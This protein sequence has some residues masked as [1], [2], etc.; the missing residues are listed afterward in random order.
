MLELG[1][2]EGQLMAESKSFSE[3]IAPNNSEE[4]RAKADASWSKLGTNSF[5][6]INYVRLLFYS[7]FRLSFY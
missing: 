4:N 3:P 2:P 7:V 5:R 1:V 6:Q